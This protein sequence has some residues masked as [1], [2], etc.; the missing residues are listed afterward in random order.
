MSGTWDFMWVRLSSTYFFKDFPLKDIFS[1]FK[2]WGLE[3]DRNKTFIIILRHHVP[4][5]IHFMEKTKW[6][7]K[8]KRGLYNLFT[9]QLNTLFVMGYMNQRGER[10]AGRTTFV[11]FS[12]SCKLF[13]PP[14]KLKSL[15]LLKK[16]RIYIYNYV[17]SKFLIQNS[18]TR[19]QFL[20]NATISSILL[21]IIDHIIFCNV[22]DKW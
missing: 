17:S 14:V 4:T 7:Y 8:K 5:A 1:F 16:E 3:A 21:P 13:S 20:H 22:P 9:A 19:Y 18:V 2:K 11:Y 15:E 12:P 6:S 10:V